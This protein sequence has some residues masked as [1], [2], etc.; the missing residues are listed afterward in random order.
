[1]TFLS[2]SAILYGI[3]FFIERFW[4]LLLLLFLY[5]LVKKRWQ[6]I[7]KSFDGE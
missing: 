4:P 5:Y 7:K 1:M 2:F 3:L 6:D